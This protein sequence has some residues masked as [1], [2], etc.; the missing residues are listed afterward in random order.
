M[1]GK[2]SDKVGEDQQG[3]SSPVGF[4]FSPIV[5]ETRTL[6]HHSSKQQF[7][8]KKNRKFAQTKYFLVVVLIF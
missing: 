3:Q 7:H 6:Y 5:P 1:P 4:F 8:K 2:R